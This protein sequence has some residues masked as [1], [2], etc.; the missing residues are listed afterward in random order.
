MNVTQFFESEALKRERGELF[1]WNI[2]TVTR[3]GATDFGAERMLRSLGRPK[4]G[5]LGIPMFF[6][7]FRLRC[8]KRNRNVYHAGTLSEELPPRGKRYDAGVFF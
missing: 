1:P 8:P 5:K 2:A 3:F 4:M 6:Y 7:G